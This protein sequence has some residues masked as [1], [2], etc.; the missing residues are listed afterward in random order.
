MSLHTPDLSSSARDAIN[1][2]LADLASRPKYAKRGLSRAMA[3]APEPDLAVAAPHDIYNLPLSA[4]V[5][6]AKPDSAEQVGRRCL[7]TSQGEPIATVE[8]PDPDGE[9]GIVTTHG[10]FTKSTAEAV[11]SVESS[12]EVADGEYD[13]RMLRV[14][15]IYLMALWLKDRQGQDDIFVPLSP[16]PAGLEA[17]ARYSWDDLQAQLKEPATRVIA[18]ERKQRPGPAVA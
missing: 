10:P 1:T 17:G 9:S 11:G 8:L 14:P 2:G 6:S 5:E 3:G 7:V 15:G 4:L 18:D 16:A 13:L 12:S